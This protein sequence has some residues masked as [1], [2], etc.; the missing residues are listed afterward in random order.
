M[1]RDVGVARGT[2]FVAGRNLALNKK[3]TIGLTD[4]CLISRIT[5]RDSYNTRIV[6][7][8]VAKAIESSKIG[9]AVLKRKDF[10]HDGQRF[11][12]PSRPRSKSFYV[13]PRKRKIIN[14]IGIGIP[15]SQSKIYPVAPACLIPFVKCI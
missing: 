10:R 9:S 5:I 13:Q 15:R 12:R 2:L 11:R 8:A 4:G 1:C 7:N 14:K 3:T 6:S